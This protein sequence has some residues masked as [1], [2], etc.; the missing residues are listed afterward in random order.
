MKQKHAFDLRVHCENERLGLLEFIYRPT[1][2]AYVKWVV[3]GGSAV[4]FFLSSQ[5]Y[6]F[7]FP[8]YTRLGLVQ[9]EKP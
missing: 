6:F 5:R 2:I 4:F 9:P 8:G 7:L 3:R 1:H